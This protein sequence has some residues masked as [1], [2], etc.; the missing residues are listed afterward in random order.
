VDTFVLWRCFTWFWYH[1]LQYAKPGVKFQGN[2]N[3]TFGDF[4]C[5]V[6]MPS[7]LCFCLVGR[8]KLKPLFRA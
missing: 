8:Y 7:V 5:C 6:I 4:G 2:P 1:S 3:F